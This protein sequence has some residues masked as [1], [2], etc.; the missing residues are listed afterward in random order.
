MNN[1]QCAEHKRYCRTSFAVL[2][3][4]LVTFLKTVPCEH[5]QGAI[6]HYLNI[7]AFEEFI[8]FGTFRS[9][10]KDYPF[11]TKGKT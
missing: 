6:M 9:G 7:V 11:G 8:E 1:E 10:I 5:H 3:L 4:S 2:Q